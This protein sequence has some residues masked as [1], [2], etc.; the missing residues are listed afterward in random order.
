ML[1]N[2]DT[3]ESLTCDRNPADV[4][5]VEGA[6]HFHAGD[7]FSCRGRLTAAK[8]AACGHPGHLFVWSP[9]DCVEAGLPVQAAPPCPECGA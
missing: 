1:T 8:P 9:A 7:L 3:P 2:N 4:V 6:Y 5:V